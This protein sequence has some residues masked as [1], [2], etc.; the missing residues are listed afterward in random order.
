M[1]KNKKGKQ[2]GQREYMRKLYDRYGDQADILVREY[3]N[4]ERN[5]IV[6]RAR[7]DYNL[8][9]EQYARAL[10]RDGKRRGWLR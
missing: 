4:G 6:V 5:R 10:Y 3:A 2:T 9:P 8:T 7:N 1:E